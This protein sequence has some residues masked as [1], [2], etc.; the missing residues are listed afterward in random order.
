MKV[1][2]AEDHCQIDAITLTLQWT[3]GSW[4]KGRRVAQTSVASSISSEPDLLPNV[5]A[6]TST[7]NANVNVTPNV[8]ALSPSHITPTAS[9]KDKDTPNSSSRVHTHCRRTATWTTDDTRYTYMTISAG[10]LPVQGPLLI[11]SS[12][13]SPSPSGVCSLTPR[14]KLR[15]SS[16]VE[17]NDDDIVPLLPHPTSPPQCPPSFLIPLGSG[18]KPQPRH[19]VKGQ[20]RKQHPTRHH[21]KAEP[22]RCTLPLPTGL[23]VRKDDEERGPGRGSRERASTSTTLCGSLPAG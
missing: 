6:S 5:N 21:A 10:R 1:M 23:G 7:A 20:S 9:R 14:V 13:A 11:P 3:W 19:K 12:S 15:Y 17:A 16:T 18:P 22:G 2:N 4:R 8:H